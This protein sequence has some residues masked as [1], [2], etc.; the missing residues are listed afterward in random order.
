MCV[1]VYY[2]LIIENTTSQAQMGPAWPNSLPA[3][4]P[5]SILSCSSPCK[6]PYRPAAFLAGPQTGQQYSC[7]RVF[8][9]A[10]SFSWNHRLLPDSHRAH[11]L[12]S[13]WL[14]LCYHLLKE[15]FP[16]WGNKRAPLVTLC[17]LKCICLHGTSPHFLKYLTS[18]ILLIPIN[19]YVLNSYIKRK[20]LPGYL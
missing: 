1:S 6:P 4:P 8:T 20:R 5:S 14:L 16:L 11:S 18:R 17:P 3:P 10:I 13:V 7:L 19:V 2:I 15:V 9:W 12:H